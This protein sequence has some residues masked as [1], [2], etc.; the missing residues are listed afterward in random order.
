MLCVNF[1]AVAPTIF[2]N[3]SMNK[4]SRLSSHNYSRITS[5]DNNNYYGGG[6][7]KRRMGSSIIK[8]SCGTGGAYEELPEGL[9]KELMPKHVAVIMDGNRRWA[10]SRGLPV[11]LG[12]IAGRRAMKQLTRNCKKFGVQVLTVFAFSTENWIRPKEEV[13]FLMNLFEEVIRSDMEELIQ[14]DVRVSVVGNVGGLRPSLQSLISSSS[15]RSKDNKG[16]DMVTALNYSGR[17]D[18]TEATKQIAR[19]V[20]DGVL[21]SVEDIDETLIEKHLQT[22]VIEESSYRNPDLLIRT[23][24]ELRLSNFMLWQSAYTELIFVDKLFPDF[25]EGDLVEA[26]TLFQKR[27]RRYGGHKY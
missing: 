24:G 15:E 10:K 3:I 9:E 14:N 2:N 17:H 18:I 25:N 23:S 5:R 19:K 21:G 11:Q 6:V 27:Q 26:L 12:H 4:P 13:N 16:M 22:N 20:K 1:P 7:V 8:S